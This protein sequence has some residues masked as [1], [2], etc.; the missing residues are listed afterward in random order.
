MAEVAASL[1]TE[2]LTSLL[3]RDVELL[4]GVHEE[5]ED[6]KVELEFITCFLK[7]ADAMAAR[8]HQGSTSIITWVKLVRETAFRIEDAIDDYILHL[9]VVNSHEHH[10]F[11]KAYLCKAAKFLEGMKKRHEIASEL[12]DIRISVR[13]IG[14]K[15]KR[16]GLNVSGNTVVIRRDPRVG[17][18]FVHD[19]ELVGIDSPRNELVRRLI[20][21]P[22]VRTVVSLVGMGGIGKTTLARK[23]YENQTVVQ[24]FDCHAW[25][26]VTQS[27]HVEEVLRTL[28]RRFY[29]ARKE[30]PPDSIGRMDEEE[31][32]GKSRE[33]LHDKRY[34][35]VFDDVWNQDFWHSIEH[36]LLD[37]NKGCRIIIT[38]RN[39][40]V[41]EFCKKSSLIH[42][43]NLR[44]LPLELARELLHR[45]AFRF[46]P[47]KQCPP[48]LKDLSLD[49]VR[50][51]QGLPLAIVAIGGL[52]STKGKDV[53]QWKSLHNQF[54]AEFDSNPHLT[55]IKKIL[56]F[57]YHDLP[58]YLKSCFLYLGMFPEDHS[59]R[60]G[61]LFRLWVAEGFV[62]QKQHATLEEVAREYLIELIHR[63]L[64]QVESIDSMGRVR[65]CRVHDLMREVI[66][67][68]SEE[69][70]LIQTSVRNLESFKGKVR[71]LSLHDRTNNNTGGSSKS[72][73]HSIIAFEVADIPESLFITLSR[74][75][76]FLKELD[77]EGVPLSY[78]HEE[79]GDLFHL[80]YL[81]LRDTKVTMLPESIGKLHNLQTLDLKRSLVHALPAAMNKL[82]N[83]Q[84]LAAYYTIYDRNSNFHS[85]RGVKMSNSFANLDSLEKLF[86]VCVET[87]ER[88]EFFIELARLKQLKKLGISRLK[89]KHG[90]ALCTAIEQ[91]NNLQSLS[92]TAKDEGFLELQSITC[93]PIFLRSLCLRGRLTKL[94]NW[95]SKLQNLVRIGLHWSRISDD[96][97]KI[98]GVLPNLLKF[99]LTNGY[100]GAQLHFEKGYFNGLKE[101]ALRMLNG[102]NRLTIDEGALPSL[103]WLSIGP[104][105]YL[106][107]LP[108]T[109]S[110][111]KSLKH[112]AFH[113]MPNS[114]AL[115]LVP[116]EGADHWKVEHIPNV[117][118]CCTNGSMQCYVYRLG[119]QRLL[120]ALR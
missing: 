84:Y 106:E 56:S 112:L 28:L 64:V 25:V 73:A 12:R 24:H 77:F 39:E 100:D 60:C 14:Q 3:S 49:I 71:H 54:S 48:E 41:V 67:S 10:G 118:F 1:A 80:R 85:R 107:E 57:S 17:M 55:D 93:P 34:V 45:T 36:V 94:P 31:L 120:Q 117:V 91:M 53:L 20:S 115:K 95:V 111:L 70:N 87:L 88:D 9:H 74:D 58:Y 30:S 110:S 29:E 19:N 42:V 92:I 44:P 43:H 82:H 21:G 68:K 113:N 72:Q 65:E 97:L 8:D 81:S 86:S 78:V 79:L 75:F 35:A 40:K 116:N 22:P 51:C 76:K 98:L 108:W 66:L 90:A 15:R 101:L 27:F 7:E 119:D 37:N 2:K 63:S 32:I 5:V 18:Q 13:G 61:R 59:I 52:L 99:Q 62:K 38:T 26:T 114:F 69:L 4:R 109:V 83:L 89:P 102:L 96:S 47:E 50:R 11:I 16:Y 103:E 6:I 46:D 104:C 33:Y 23:V 105:R